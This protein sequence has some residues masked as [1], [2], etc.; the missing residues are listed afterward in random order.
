MAFSLWC[1]DS[2]GDRERGRGR[3]GEEGKEKEMMGYVVCPFRRT[4]IPSDQG[5]TFM[6]SLNLITS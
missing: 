1:M 2:E 3:G 4:I 5:P 6:T